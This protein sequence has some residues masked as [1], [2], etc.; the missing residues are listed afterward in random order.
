MGQDAT[1]ILMG[2]TTSN[3]KEVS[4]HVGSLAAGLIVRLKSDDTISI[5]KADG[6]VL[7]VSLGRDLSNIGYSAICRKGLGVPVLLASGFTTPVK[8]GQVAIS[9]T[10]GQAKAY[11]GTGDTYMNAY[12]VSGVLT[13]LNEDGTTAN[14]ALIDMPGGL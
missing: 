2:T 7:G 6:G 1:K 3:V 11:T 8:G 9:D 14:V 12:Y 10:T 5:A 13:G 4:N